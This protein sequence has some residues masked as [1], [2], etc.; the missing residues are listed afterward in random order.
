[1]ARL[2]TLDEAT[3]LLPRLRELLTEMQEKKVVLDSVREELAMMTRASAGNGH[4]MAD[5]VDSK[6]KEGQTLAE[7]LNALL[8]E[9]NELGCE[10]KG[11]DEGLVD[12][13]ARR[14]GRTVYL[15]WKLGE[16]GIDYWHEQ[17]TGFSGRQ[18]L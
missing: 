14:D 17:D 4:L 10:L 1:M 15:C 9:L 2:F 12:F 7:R 6:R 8:E 5:E 18:P 16:D 11:L 13:P 3:A